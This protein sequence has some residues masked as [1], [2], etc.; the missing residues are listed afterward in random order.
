MDIFDF[1]KE[2]NKITNKA[3]KRIDNLIMK[4]EKQF[5]EVGEQ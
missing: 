2:W 1:Q 4:T 3:I 5:E